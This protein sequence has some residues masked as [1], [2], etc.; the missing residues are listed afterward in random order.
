MT[1]ILSWMTIDYKSRNDLGTMR[2]EIVTNLTKLLICL[3]AAS[4]FA[5]WRKR[6]VS[7]ELT[8]IGAQR[9]LASRQLMTYIDEAE[10]WQVLPRH[11]TDTVWEK[12]FSLAD[13][14][15]STQTASSGAT[16]RCPFADQPSTRTL[17]EL[18]ERTLFVFCLVA[19][20]AK[21]RGCPRGTSDDILEKDSHS[22]ISSG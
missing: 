21:W 12:W 18:R 16:L 9:I 19:A 17:S 7:C 15:E 3:G 13:E 10:W 2:S 11:R 1:A 5:C 22:A 6:N 14:I 4:F 8:R 20:N